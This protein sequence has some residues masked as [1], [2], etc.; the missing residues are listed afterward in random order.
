MR[1]DLW[2]GEDQIQHFVQLLVQGYRLQ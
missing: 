2:D 1:E